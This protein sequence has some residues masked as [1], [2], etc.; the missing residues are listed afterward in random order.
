M[1]S[2]SRSNRKFRYPALSAVLGL[3]LILSACGGGPTDSGNPAVHITSGTES[4]TATYELAGVAFDDTGISGMTYTLGGAEAQPFTAGGGTFSVSLTLTPG[5]NPITV[6]ATDAAGNSGSDS[7]TV[8]YNAPPSGTSPNVDVAA[9]G[10]TIVI[11]GSNFGTSGN[12]TIGD[13]SAS[14]GSWTDSEISLTIPDNA[15]GGPQTITVAS[16]HGTSTFEIFIGVDFPEGTLEELAAL[17]LPRGTAVRLGAD[18]F[19]QSTTEVELDNLSLY[20]QGAGLTIVDSGASQILSLLADYDHDLV[21][22]DLTLRTDATLIGPSTPESVGGLATAASGAADLP[23]ASELYEAALAAGYDSHRNGG[24][25][26]TQSLRSGSFTLRD[27][28]IEEVTGLL[29]VL[30][31]NPATISAY[32]GALHV[33]NVTFTGTTSALVLLTAGDVTVTDSDVTGGAVVAS[34][35]GNVTVENSRLHSSAAGSSF[36][37]TGVLYGRHLRMVDSSFES[38]S[39]DVMIAAVDA[40]LGPSSGLP[41]GTGSMEITGTTIRALAADPAAPTY[42][43]VLIMFA[44]SDLSTI[45]DN[46]I[47]A[48]RELI[49]GTMGG[50]FDF[51]DNTVTVGHSLIASSPVGLQQGGAGTLSF[52]DFRNNTV[53]WVT[54]GG[55]EVGGDFRVLIDSNTFNGQSGQALSLYDSGSLTGVEF[56]AQDNTFAGFDEALYIELDGVGASPADLRF[57]GNIFDF[58]IDALGKV[59]V[60]QDVVEATIDADGNR[61][62]T[63]DDVAV[64]NS[65]IERLGSTP[66]DMMEITGVMP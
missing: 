29:G 9:I 45:S 57:N 54:G 50:N 44:A 27:L 21:F 56:S 28:E 36:A 58:P 22:A 19:G 4:A 39:E 13:V 61:W 55:L 48:H 40:L 31:L 66:G 47:T 11:S 41:F 2:T 3:V 42:A 51:H 53:N 32:P 8:Q 63:E 26:S 5:A 14:T 43:G 65:Y 17:A 18:T 38:Y 7:V 46:T 35:A 12:L 20:G 6:T 16:A 10:D 24:E 1:T 59:A 60:L 25:L 52:L 62:G 64:L 34:F 23:G 33:H 15:P 30:T 37:S 49:L